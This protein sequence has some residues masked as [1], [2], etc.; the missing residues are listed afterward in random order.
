MPWYSAIRSPASE[1]LQTA[2]GQ[3]LCRGAEAFCRDVPLI[4]QDRATPECHDAVGIL[5]IEPY[6]TIVSADIDIKGGMG[7]RFQHGI[8]PDQGT[9]QSLAMQG[10]QT[11]FSTLHRA[12][13]TWA[14]RSLS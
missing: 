11:D 4:N 3:R 13:S 7:N 5:A 8:D 1:E 2:T 6:I 14:I 9:W 10:G 12:V